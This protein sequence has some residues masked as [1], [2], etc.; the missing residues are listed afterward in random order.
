MLLQLLVIRLTKLPEAEEPYYTPWQRLVE[1]DMMMKWYSY[2][3]TQCGVPIPYLSIL[4]LRTRPQSVRAQLKSA[5]PNTWPQGPMHLKSSTLC[6][7]LIQLKPF[8]QILCNL[9]IALLPWHPLRCCWCP[10]AL[11]I[12]A[13]SVGT[14]VGAVVSLLGKNCLLSSAHTEIFSVFC[15]FWHFFLFYNTKNGGIHLVHITPNISMQTT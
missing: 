2:L 6:T 9:Q 10:G 5:A 11:V 3:G 12:I 7:K 15:Y 8:L 14:S 4:T 1:W 13:S